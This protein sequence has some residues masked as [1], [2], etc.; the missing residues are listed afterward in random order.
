MKNEN[1]IFMKLYEEGRLD[2]L[3]A[4]IKLRIGFL[5]LDKKKKADNETNIDV[6][7]IEIEKDPN[8]PHA[9][10]MK[11]FQ[12]QIEKQEGLDDD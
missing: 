9:L 11:G 7:D 2:E 1:E 10:I 4:S 12:E 5:L 6:N 8:D 3:P